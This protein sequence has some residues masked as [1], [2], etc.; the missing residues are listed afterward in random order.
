MCV[1]NLPI[2]PIYKL[3]PR[4]QQHVGKRFSLT[5]RT[6]MSQQKDRKTDRQTDRHIHTLTD[7]QTYTYIL[8]TF[9]KNTRE[10]P[11]PAK[12]RPLPLV[13][14]VPRSTQ[15]CLPMA[16]AAH[17]TS[18]VTSVRD[19]ACPGEPALL[20]SMPQ[21]CR[22]LFW[23]STHAAEAHEISSLQPSNSTHQLSPPP[24]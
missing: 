14:E 19:I 11:T 3:R 24:S 10:N 22:I 5:S 17:A 20:H 8:C 18:A 21:R 2:W 15:P 23:F 7:R 12:C 4:E 6:K 13:D 9:G 1:L 16:G